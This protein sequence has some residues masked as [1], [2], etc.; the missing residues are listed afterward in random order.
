MLCYYLIFFLDCL[1]RTVAILSLP[2]RSNDITTCFQLSVCVKWTITNHFL[3]DCFLSWPLPCVFQS[4]QCRF[5]CLSFL[6]FALFL[7]P[8]LNTA[9]FVL[10]MCVCAFS[11]LALSFLGV[12]FPSSISLFLI[13]FVSNIVISYIF[14]AVSLFICYLL[15]PFFQTLEKRLIKLSNRFL[16]LNQHVIYLCV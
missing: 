5:W 3:S 14:I 15:F 13:F 1:Q 7:Y 11:R 9:Y 12:R 10:Y 8:C 16:Y 2:P 4:F 6:Y